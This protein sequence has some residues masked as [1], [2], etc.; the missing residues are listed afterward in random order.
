MTNSELQTLLATNILDRYTPFAFSCSCKGEHS[1]C[2]EAMENPY[3]YG[4]MDTLRRVSAYIN[5]FDPT[6]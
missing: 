2:R 3:L 1:E 6:N 5:D 4:V